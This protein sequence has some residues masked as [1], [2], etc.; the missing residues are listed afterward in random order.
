VV[1]YASRA[2]Y[3][4]DLTLEPVHGGAKRRGKGTRIGMHKEFAGA[5]ALQHDLDPSGIPVA[6]EPHDGGG[7]AMHAFGKADDSSFGLCPER[8]RDVGMVRVQDDLH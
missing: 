1:W 2:A 4:S 3:A 8:F 5:C 6:H 7:N